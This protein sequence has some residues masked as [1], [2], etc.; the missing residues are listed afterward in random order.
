ME[1]VGGGGKPPALVVLKEGRGSVK[2]VGVSGW[3]CSHR[4]GAGGGSMG[5]PLRCPLGG[6][7]GSPRWPRAPCL[8][9]SAIAVIRLTVLL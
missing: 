8:S 2:A 4:G 9:P 5:V 6:L 7:M 3:R 1:E